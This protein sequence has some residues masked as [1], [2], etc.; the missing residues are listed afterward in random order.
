MDST[1]EQNLEAAPATGGG[2]AVTG[3]CEPLRAEDQLLVSA[4]EVGAALERMAEAELV[5]LGL[6]AEPEPTW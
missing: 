2:A 4:L 1:D 6:V 3:W 5:A